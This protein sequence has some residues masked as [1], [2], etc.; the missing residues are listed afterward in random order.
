[1]AELVRTIVCVIKVIETLYFGVV[2]GRGVVSQYIG[3]IRDREWERPRGVEVG[4]PVGWVGV[5][6]KI[7]SSNQSRH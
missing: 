3:L 1:M 2:R 6:S 5:R 4:V 7:S